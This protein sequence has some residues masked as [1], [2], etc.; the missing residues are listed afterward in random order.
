MGIHYTLL[1]VNE[2]PPS[3]PSPNGRSHVTPI[4]SEV[5]PLGR[6][7]AAKRGRMPRAALRILPL[8]APARLRRPAVRPRASGN[9]PFSAG[10]PAGESAIRGLSAG[11]SRETF[12][13]CMTNGGAIT[14]L[15]P[16]WRARSGRCRL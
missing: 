12:A 9:C 4:P 1:T 10:G 8:G 2:C 15:P 16:F 7:L 3:N 6:R 5:C 11:A 14:G 13:G